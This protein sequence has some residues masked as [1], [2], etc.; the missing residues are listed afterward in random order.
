MN[1]GQAS[2]S[3]KT[4]H[5]PRALLIA[6]A[7]N[8][9][10]ASVP[11]VGWSLARAIGRAT[12]AHVVTQVRNRD[13]FLRAG[14][15]EGS[16]FT[17]I[18]TE[19]ILAPLWQLATKLRGGST[20]AWT[21]HTALTRLAY[22]LFERAVWQ[23]FKSRIADHEFDVV[24]RITPLTPT[25]PSP[26]SRW[27]SRANVPFVLGPLNGGVPWPEGFDAERRGEREWLS[28][29]RSAYKL[30]P[31]Y[32]STLTHAAA[33]M[34][35]SRH[36]LNALPESV[37]GKCFY[38]PEN[39]VD[40]ERFFRRSGPYRTGPLRACFV[41]RLVPYKGPDMLVEAAAPMLAA[42]HLTLDIVGDGPLMTELKD[43]VHRL[44][45]DAAVR[46]HGWV[47]HRRVQDLLCEANVLTF[48]SIREFGGGV[49]LEAMALGVVPIVVDYAGPS[50]LVDDAVGYKIPL[51]S[52]EQIV[53]G[54]RNTL[55]RLIADPQ[56]LSRLSE[57]CVAR[58]R[59]Q[60]TW[61]AKAKQIMQVYDWVLGRR[62]SRPDL[63]SD[64]A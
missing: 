27:C 33:I 50:E 4:A 36:T 2:S 6:E 32:R 15:R 10:W 63:V 45:L 34:A 37:R 59:T 43:M 49:V 3:L 30:L 28:Y 31:G 17:A 64:G 21:V 61:E 41:G 58:V 62:A 48:P 13:A 39:A 25:A 60:F 26:L 9:E 11:L 16:D 24:H 35:G 46:L 5:S 19:R 20:R 57:Q 23:Q 51:G 29:V 8:P 47:D 55:Q 22:P 14:L 53:L 38:V 18:D 7:A 1:P 12:P 52:R 42:G 44:H 40:P 54:L 56:D